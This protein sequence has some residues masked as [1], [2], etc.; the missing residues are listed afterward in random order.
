LLDPLAWRRAPR[1]LSFSWGF[2]S[3]WGWGV[4]FSFAPVDSPLRAGSGVRRQQTGDPSP[5]SSEVIFCDDLDV[6]GSQR[7]GTR[8]RI[9]GSRLPITD[10]G[11]GLLGVFDPRR[12]SMR[13][14][15]L[16]C[17]QVDFGGWGR[18]GSCIGHSSSR[19]GFMLEYT[20]G[21]ES[22]ASD[23]RVPL[24]QAPQLE[25]GG[26]RSI[27]FGSVGS[28]KTCKRRVRRGARRSPSELIW[29]TQTTRKR[30][31]RRRASAQSSAAG[32]CEQRAA[33]CLKAVADS[34]V[35]C[36][37]KLC[38]NSHQ[39][40]QEGDESVDVRAGKKLHPA[41]KWGLMAG[42]A[43]RSDDRN[44]WLCHLRGFRT[45]TSRQGHPSSKKTGC[46]NSLPW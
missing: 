8:L 45:L 5:P 7:L 38:L 42:S 1:L 30:E 41:L 19:V 20:G 21:V 37:G 2:V 24:S 27:T 34:L 23:Q 4:C 3:G 46:L 14:G 40:D 6:P 33:F 36:E 44:Q 22:G 12:F 16:D 9:G 28:S 10:S 29:K 17:R 35:F 26:S 32:L 31:G 18:E 39:P 25:I 13:S 43:W 11:W 15:V